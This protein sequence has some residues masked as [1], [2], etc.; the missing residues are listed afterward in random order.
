MHAGGFFSVTHNQVV[1]K[2]SFLLATFPFSIVL[3]FPLRSS[4]SLPVREL[5]LHREL[6]QQ[7]HKLF[8]ADT[9]IMVNMVLER[10]GILHVVGA[11]PSAAV[12]DSVP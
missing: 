11:L 10:I 4:I 12:R 7:E 8:R 2:I 6:P 9:A 5:P 1:L 3:S